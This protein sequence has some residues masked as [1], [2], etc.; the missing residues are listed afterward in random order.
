MVSI[1]GSVKYGNRAKCG[2]CNSSYRYCRDH[3]Q[4]WSKLSEETK[5]EYIKANRDQGGRGRKRSLVTVTKARCV[6]SSRISYGQVEVMDYKDLKNDQKYLNELR[7]GLEIQLAT[8]SVRSLK[9]D[10]VESRR[11]KKKGCKWFGWSDAEAQ[12]HWDT[13]LRNPSVP[14]DKDAI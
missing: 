4:D 13:A 12:K 5:K 7:L 3:V 11:F 9:Q 1:K 10:F 6:E 2:K 14:R 8:F